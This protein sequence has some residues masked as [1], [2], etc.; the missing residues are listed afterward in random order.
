YYPYTKLADDQGNSLPIIYRYRPA[1]LD[2]LNSTYG[3]KLLSMQFAPLKDI[4]EGYVKTKNQNINILIGAKYN[5]SSVFSVNINYNYN[6]GFN[7]QNGFDGPNSFYVRN[8]V[9]LFTTPLD[10]VDPIFGT[11]D[12]ARRQIPIG[13]I[14][15]PRI[16]YTSNQT[17]RGQLN[18]EKKWNEKNQ[19]SA[20]AGVDI[21]QNYIL[22][23]YDSYYGYDENTKIFNNR[24][25]FYDNRLPNLFGDANTGLS[26]GQIPAV[27]DINDYKI[28]TF[29]V[30]SNAAYTYARRYTLSG[31]IRKDY[32]SEFGQGADQ[33]S[34]PFYSVGG[35]WNIN[36]ED[37]YNLALLPLLKFRATF[38][39]N[40]NVNPLVYSR[41]ILFRSSFVDSNSGL[42]YSSTSNGSQ[43]G[44]SNINLRP[45]RTGTFNL[46]I[47]FGF[48]GNRISGSVEYYNKNTSDLLS[49]N[50]IDPTTGF[51]TVVYNTANLNGKGIDLTINSLNFQSGLFRWNSNFLFSWN[52]NKVLKVFSTAADNVGSF[53]LASGNLKAGYPY[54]KLFGLKWAGL[55]PST[56]DPRGYLNGKIVT[57]TPDATGDNLFNQITSAPMSEAHYFGSAVPVYYGSFRNTFSYGS[58][59]VSTSILYKLGY[60]FRRPGSSLVRYTLLYRS[61]IPQGAEYSRRW[62]NPGDEQ[63][64][65]VPSLTTANNLSR[66]NMYYFSEINVLMADHIRLQ[67]INLSY[68]FNNKKWFIKNPR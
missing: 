55:D 53:V 52:T 10:Y 40:G 1:F 50:P 60:F 63:K 56:G 68:S 2:L 6:R 46:G 3:D 18:V 64:T 16:Q 59:S 32:S 54:S 66:D 11:A 17:L 26:V 8:L 21:G 42:P 67:E 31:S 57:I 15:R 5:L 61:G 23:R 48:R 22:N 4:D 45:E 38:G 49:A 24:L 28:R 36:N 41:P 19:L 34:T 13:G 12:P 9:N 33:K 7:E 30:Y 37:F 65:N 35:S 25:N 20:I 51:N 62:Q 29:S 58:F 39:Y 43:G 44:V 47:D 27:L 14:Y